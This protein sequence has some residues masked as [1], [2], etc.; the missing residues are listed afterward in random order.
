MTI[1]KDLFLSI[2]AMD[3]YNRGYG[4]GIADGNGDVVDGVDRDGLG[5]AG[6]RVGAAFIQD[7]DL[8]ADSET[9]SFYALSY[10]ITGDTA[11]EGL[12]DKTITS[13][14][15]SKSRKMTSGISA[16]SSPDIIEAHNAI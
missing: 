10:D 3:V 12:A 2:L 9:N 6:E 5:E 15:T 1:S 4:A 13:F 7:T 14:D 16:R 8:P 11:P